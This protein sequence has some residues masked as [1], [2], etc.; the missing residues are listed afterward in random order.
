MCGQDIQECLRTRIWP[1][2]LVSLLPDVSYGTPEYSDMQGMTMTCP[3][4]VAGK[5]LALSYKGGHQLFTSD[6]MGTIPLSNNWDTMS[7]LAL[8]RRQVSFRNNSSILS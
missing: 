8:L 1:R 7:Q 4:G 6:G 3:T 5:Q 2:K